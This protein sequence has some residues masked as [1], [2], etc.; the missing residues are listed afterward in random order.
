L[1]TSSSHPL[2]S[3]PLTL[4]Q[5]PARSVWHHIFLDRFPDP[6]G[7]GLTSSRFSDPRKNPKYRFGVF[8]VGQTFEV[9]FLETIVRDRRN[10]N[11][12]MLVLSA[13]D[14][15]AFVHVPI[16][17]TV[18]LN[19][20]DLRGGSPVALGV[21]TNAVRASSHRLGQRASLA[22]YQRPDQPDGIWY[23]SRL[24]GEDNLAVYDRAVR[25][26]A[27]GPRRKLIQCPELSAVLDAYR[28]A[29]V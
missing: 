2:A 27:A 3:A 5:V 20:V 14:L 12:G 21:P 22:V 29:L 8:Y 18:S 16:T 17:V 26:L 19:V 10:G 15:D 6:L 13:G 4:A 23:P 25:K 28:V 11:P 7:F 1:A 24:N 9:A